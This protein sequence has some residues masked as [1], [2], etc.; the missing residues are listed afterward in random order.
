MRHVQWTLWPCAAPI[1]VEAVLLQSL[2]GYLPHL[3]HARS[4]SLQASVLAKLDV[5]FATEQRV[6]AFGSAAAR[7]MRAYATQVEVL[8]RLRNGGQQFVNARLLFQLKQKLLSL[9]EVRTEAASV[10]TSSDK[11][12][13]EMII[14]DWY[15]D[16][17][18]NPTREIRRRD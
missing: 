4:A 1:W 16:D 8:R 15:L 12:P 9:T 18:G 14:G 10:S 11:P 7:L 13:I 6:A 2:P 17:L 5:A 3:H